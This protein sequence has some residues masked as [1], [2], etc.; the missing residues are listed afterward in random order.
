VNEG[1]YAESADV[2]VFPATG[3]FLN[4]SFPPSKPA[5]QAP[6]FT[7]QLYS[8]INFTIPPSKPAAQARASPPPPPPIP[9]NR[10]PVRGTSFSPTESAMTSV[11]SLTLSIQF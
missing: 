5:A 4:F 6:V 3:D 9:Y 11:Y 7:H 8:F 10:A 2:V 1:R